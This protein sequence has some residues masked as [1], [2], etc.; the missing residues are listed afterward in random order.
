CTGALECVVDVTKCVN[1]S[2]GRDQLDFAS[3]YTALADVAAEFL[4]DSDKSAIDVT[5]GAIHSSRRGQCDKY[6][7]QQVLNKSLATVV[8]V[9]LLKQSKQCS[10]MV[11][12]EPANLNASCAVVV[13]KKPRHFSTNDE[14]FC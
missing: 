1:W 5:G 4:T 2:A 8:I 11:P 3:R 10:H 6:D 14:R 12:P 7:D 13:I 9:K